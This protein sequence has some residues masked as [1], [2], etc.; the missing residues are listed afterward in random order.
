MGSKRKSANKIY[1]TIKR[2][3]PDANVLC[4][5]FCG[6][7]A[8]GAKFMNKGWT[9]I[10]NDK[11]KYIVAL[12][13]KVLFEGLPEDI[14]TKFV[15]RE[16]FFD[17]SRDNSDNYEDWYVGY[18]QC[19]WSFGNNQRDYI[20]G[21]NIEAIKRAGHELVINCNS[22]LI[23]EIIGKDAVDKVLSHNNRISRRFQLMKCICDRKFELEQLEQLQRI[24]QLERLQ[25]IQQLQ[26]LERLQQLQR[27][28]QLQ[29]LER[30]QRIEQ[31]EQL[32]RIQQLQRLERQ[33]QLQQLER[34]EQLQQLQRLERLQQLEQ[35]EQL[36]RIQQL[37]RL[38][39]LEQLQ[40]IEQLERLERLQ[41]LELHS[42]N[43]N[44]VTIP[45]GSIVYCDPPYA[46]T[47]EYKEGSFNHAE[48]WEWCRKISKTNKIYIS[49]YSAPPD[50][51]PVITF[52]QKSTLQGG[53]QKHNNQPKERLFVPIGQEGIVSENYKQQQL[54]P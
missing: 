14:V 41:Q 24:E 40:R 25:R 18:V 37:Q 51:V 1:S 44:E 7:F 46:G 16:M 28:Q 10:A 9:V 6:G 17:I 35:L 3:N 48:F 30:L 15:T 47:A 36:Q 42:L 52:E 29:R 20:F 8:I 53:T 54:F 4:D 22:D 38:E 39:R 23:I 27:I 12:L 21:K 2:L 43:Y 45:H 13:Q 19:V 5:L 49:E 32:Q 11:N 33:Q 26:R 50:F 31:L 34:L